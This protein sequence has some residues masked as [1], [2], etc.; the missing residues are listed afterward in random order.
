MHRLVRHLDMKRVFVRVGINGDG[1]NSEPPRGFDDATGNFT[2]IG[3]EDFFYF[4]GQDI[5][6]DDGGLEET[7]EAHLFF[8]Q[9]P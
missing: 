8:V 5:A 7:R 4:I 2:T 6:L 1:F 9:V 3:D